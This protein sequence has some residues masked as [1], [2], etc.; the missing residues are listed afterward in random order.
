MDSNGKEISVPLSAL[1]YASGQV[2]LRSGWSNSAG[3]S[4][5]DSEILNGLLAELQRVGYLK[6]A[7][8]PAP[9][10]AIIVQAANPGPEGNNI[11][12][13]IS[14]VVQGKGGAKLDPL[15]TTFS[16][17]AQETGEYPG[18]TLANI[19]SKLG[20]D[21]DPK[22]TG[23]VHVQ[24]GTISPSG[25]MPVELS[26]KAVPGTLKVLDKNGKNLF[27]LEARGSRNSAPNV[28][29]TISDITKDTFKLSASWEHKIDNVKI[30]APTLESKFQD[31]AYLITV[32]PPAGPPSRAYSV[33]DGK[34]D[35]PQP[36]SGG[37]AGSA[38]SL[39]L[40]SK[41]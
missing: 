14:N 13:T 28:S 16:V 34:T 20:T 24:D 26:A 38:A 25:D 23:L 17:T 40:F 27:T 33:P 9:K 7:P 4:N 22:G 32:S 37:S 5:D 10:P 1:E 18:L 35:Q 29:V 30:D 15:Q 21:K 6:S 19:A 39:T 2:D 12:I 31:L 36:L 3:L 8:P 11:K 41:Q